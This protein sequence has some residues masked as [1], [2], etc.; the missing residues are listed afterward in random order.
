MTGQRSEWKVTGVDRQGYAAVAPVLHESLL[1]PGDPVSFL[2]RWRPLMD[3][4]GYGRVLVAWDGEQAVGSTN[5][6]PFEMTLPGGPRPVAG[7]TAVGVWPTHR[8][9]GVLTALMRR[10]LADTR[11]RGEK[12]A[13]LWAS[14][15]GIYG[16]FGYGAASVQHRVSVDRPHDLLSADVPRDPSLTTVLAPPQ[17]ARADL[18]RV[19]RAVAPTRP[20]DYQ[21]D[22]SWWDRL[23][24]DDP[25]TRGESGPLRAVV[26]HD[27][28]APVGYAL[29]RSHRVPVADGG[30]RGVLDVREVAAATPAAR[31]ALYEHLFTRDLVIRVNFEHLPVDDPLWSLVADP[32]RLEV[33]PRVALWIRLVDLPGAL[34]ERSYAAPVDVVLEVADRHAP[35]N[36]GRWRLRADRAGA[37][38]DPASDAPDLSLD[39]AHLGAAFLGQF[40]VG[41]KVAAGTVAEHTPG[42]ADLLDT[43]LRVPR[44]PLCGVIF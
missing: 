1:F 24:R 6:F 21:R 40:T 44:A 34:A 41:A 15:G 18:A 16:R 13:A 37:S 42:A 33:R 35:W 5:A 29:Y 30:L 19:H 10:Q 28:R 3:A 32:L 8:R 14:E 26:V 25:Q 27:T 12:V 2:E 20:G 9:R 38:C 4:Q 31:T 23:L 17:E 11:E 7:V 22:E 43:A 39:A 36:A